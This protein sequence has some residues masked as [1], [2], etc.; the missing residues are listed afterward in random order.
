M[1]SKNNNNSLSTRQNDE[2]K[3][4]YTRMFIVYFDT[5][6]CIVS[7]QCALIND[8]QLNINTYCSAGTWT[9]FAVLYFK[10]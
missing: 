1:G 3:K 7:R 5:S 6:I 8:L 9:L 10:R 4:L 2:K